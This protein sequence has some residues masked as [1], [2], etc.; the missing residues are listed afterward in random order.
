MMEPLSQWLFWTSATRNG[1]SFFCP[2]WSTTP[3]Q[4]ANYEMEGHKIFVNVPEDHGSPMAFLVHRK[5]AS[6]VEGVRW[7]G[8]AG[9]LKVRDK[10]KYRG[11]VSFKLDIFGV[12]GSSESSLLPNDLMNLQSLI[13]AK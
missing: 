2:E 8:R 6:M 4:E 11:I 10:L 9:V 1:A 13:R 12:H 7:K 3:V 5:F